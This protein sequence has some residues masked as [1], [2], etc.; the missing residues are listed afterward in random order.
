MEIQYNF[1]YAMGSRAVIKN[2][3]NPL[4][5]AVGFGGKKQLSVGREIILID[6]I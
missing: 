4:I 6:E 3:C 5:I 1:N 2:Y